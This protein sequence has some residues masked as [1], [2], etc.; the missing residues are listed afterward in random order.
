MTT[1]HYRNSFRS[2]VI[3]R[4][5]LM[6]SIA[7]AT[8]SEESSVN[9]E[10]EVPSESGIEVPLPASCYQREAMVSDRP[11]PIGVGS[12]LDAWQMPG[13]PQESLRVRLTS[14]QGKRKPSP[15]EPC[16]SVELRQMHFPEQDSRS[17][18]NRQQ[19]RTRP[20]RHPL[21]ACDEL[22]PAMPMLSTAG[23]TETSDRSACPE[24]HP[25]TG[26]PLPSYSSGR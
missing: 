7:I 1:K 8:A 22:P 20:Q 24:P 4:L 3:G 23:I 9:F 13:T 12:S 21:P 11:S 10:T 17:G 2:E 14:P 26:F 6:D 16:C 25:G 15:A 18:P 5:R 19:E